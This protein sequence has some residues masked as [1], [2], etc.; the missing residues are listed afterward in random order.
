MSP[1][2]ARLRRSITEFNFKP[3]FVEE[4]GWDDVRT[5]PLSVQAGDQPFTLTALAQKRGLLLLLCPV[6]PAELGLGDASGAAPARSRLRW[7]GGCPVFR[8]A[9]PQPGS[10][11]PVRR[12]RRDRG[13]GRVVV[14]R[15]GARW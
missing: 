14:A 2:P 15:S 3:L 8:I 7:V 11:L 13:G 4:L 9:E 6:L 10:L 5:A 1:D 12:A